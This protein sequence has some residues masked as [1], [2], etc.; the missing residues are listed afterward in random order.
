MRMINSARQRRTHEQGRLNKGRHAAPLSQGGEWLASLVLYPFGPH[1]RPTHSTHILSLSCSATRRWA[2]DGFGVVD[3]ADGDVHRQ[4]PLLGTSQPWDWKHQGSQLK[5]SYSNPDSSN[6]TRC[7]LTAIC[8]WKT[9]ST[10]R[11]PPSSFRAWATMIA[12]C[13]W[14]ISDHWCTHHALVETGKCVHSSSPSFL[15]PGKT[16][17]WSAYQRLIVAAC[18]LRS[19]IVPVCIGCFLSWPII[20]VWQ[21]DPSLSVLISFTM[22]SCGVMRLLCA[23]P[24]RLNCCLQA[25]V[26]QQPTSS[27]HKIRFPVNCVYMCRPRWHLFHLHLLP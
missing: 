25:H 14:L 9:T 8:N 17:Q 13:T 2:V 1:Q 26:H 23:V 7:H 22:H 12:W 21:A 5:G 11:V 3:Q 4:E 6:H 24:E 27:S 15:F 16:P 18:L 20:T 10:T 19:Q